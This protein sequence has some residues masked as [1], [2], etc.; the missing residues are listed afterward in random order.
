MRVMLV[1]P[2]GRIFYFATVMLVRHS[3][4]SPHL[5]TFTSKGSLIVYRAEIIFNAF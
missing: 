3:T 2:R 4:V 1:V 5:A